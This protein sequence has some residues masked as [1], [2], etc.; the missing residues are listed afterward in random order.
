MAITPEEWECLA[1]GYAW[2]HSDGVNG[3]VVEIQKGIEFGQLYRD[4]R[5]SGST[6]LKSLQT[7][8]EE[9]LTTGKVS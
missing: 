5:F 6:L 4:H 3:R 8:H 9:W 1:R 2:G 7:A